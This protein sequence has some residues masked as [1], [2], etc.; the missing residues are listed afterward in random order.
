MTQ[1][2]EIESS[3]IRAIT[4]ALSHLRTYRLVPISGRDFTDDQVLTLARGMLDHLEREVASKKL[5]KLKK[6]VEGS[7]DGS[8]DEHSRGNS[9]LPTSGRQ[10]APPSR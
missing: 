2:S 5:A 6:S 8:D 10:I 9:L 7:G 1:R 4:M 3:A